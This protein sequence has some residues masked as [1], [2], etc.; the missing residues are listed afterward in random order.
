[1]E[2]QRARIELVL[3]T[4]LVVGAN[5]VS[6]PASAIESTRNTSED[7]QGMSLC[8]LSFKD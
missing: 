2:P 7:K 1:M 3:A 5:F 4:S 6:G 8:Q